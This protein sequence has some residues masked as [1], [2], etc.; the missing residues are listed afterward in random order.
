LK[1]AT[2]L[3]YNLVYISE[4]VQFFSLQ[5]T[6]LEFVEVKE[7]NLIDEYGKGFLHFNFVVKE[8]D[9][10][11]TNFFA[12]VHPDLKD[13]KDVYLCIPLDEKDLHPSEDH[14]QGIFNISSA[15]SLY[16][17]ISSFCIFFFS[18]YLV[19]E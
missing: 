3:I 14:D 18:F 11:L 5:S 9:G 12:E 1:L 8:T 19:I 17:F 13:E 10:K 7:R 2:E 4:L 16:F 6:D 15:N